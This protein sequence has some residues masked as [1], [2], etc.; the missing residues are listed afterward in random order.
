MKGSNVHILGIMK[1]DIHIVVAECDI[2][3]CH[4]GEIVKPLGKIKYLPIFLVVWT[5]ISM[6]FI[7]WLPK[8]GSK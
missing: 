3:Q 8:F 4:K 7:M 2:F 6:E 5:N 1:K